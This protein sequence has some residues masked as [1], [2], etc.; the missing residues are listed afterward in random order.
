MEQMAHDMDK[1]CQKKPVKYFLCHQIQALSPILQILVKEQ[2]ESSFHLNLDCPS[3]PEEWLPRLLS[4]LAS[5]GS[6]INTDSYS[7]PPPLTQLFSRKPFLPFY[8]CGID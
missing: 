1:M 8:H 7:H 5:D 6:S 2:V 4:C 3:N